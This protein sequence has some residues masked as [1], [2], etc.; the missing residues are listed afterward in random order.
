MAATHAE[1][2]EAKEAAL[3]DTKKA[4]LL[5]VALQQET[6]VHRGLRALAEVD[7]AIF[8]GSS[9]RRFNGAISFSFSTGKCPDSTRG[10]AAVRVE[11][12]QEP[13]RS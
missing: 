12:E 6:Q 7:T 9:R 8:C 10:A 2:Q 13:P 11:T 1:I 5:M 3:E 4:K